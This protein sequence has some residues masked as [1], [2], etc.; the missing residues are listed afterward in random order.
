[1]DRQCRDILVARLP[2]CRAGFLFAAVRFV[3]YLAAFCNSETR[4]MAALAKGRC[5]TCAINLVMASVVFIL[6]STGCGICA[7][8]EVKRGGLFHAFLNGRRQIPD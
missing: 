3:L 6:G 7:S 4:H 1:M 8:V 2:S 5:P